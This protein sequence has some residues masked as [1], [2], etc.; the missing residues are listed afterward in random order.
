[1]IKQPVTLPPNRAWSQPNNGFIFGSVY[2]SRNVTFDVPGVVSLSPR[3]RILT[4]ES[5]SG[6]N[7]DTV[8]AFAYG[9][10]GATASG[11]SSTDQYI[12]VTSDALYLLAGALTNIGILTNASTPS[13]SAYSDGISWN[14]GFYCTQTSDLE[15]LVAGTWTG[16][17]MSLTSSVPHPL[18]RSASGNYLL[19]GNGNK[20]EKRTT[21]GVN[22]TAL[23]FP[24]NYQVVWIRSDYSRTLIGARALDGTNGAV[25]EWDE[26]APTWTNRF[27][28][29][30]SW[31][32]SGCFRNTD[33]FVVS[34][35]GRLMK[36]NG[37]G[38]STA[39]QWP[40]YKGLSGFWDGN[41]TG[42][43]ANP[44]YQRSMAVINGHLT[45]NVNSDI[46]YGQYDSVAYEN[47]PSGLWDF[48]E[49]TGLTH[50]YGLTCSNDDTDFA[51]MQNAVGT[52]ALFPVFI[53]SSAPD[54]SDGSFFL[55][56]A[57]MED[58]ATTY[59]TVVTCVDDGLNVGQLTTTR[60]ETSDIADDAKKLWVKYRGVFESTDLIRFKYKDQ[61]LEGL[62]F[63]TV[64]GGITWTSTTV[65]TSTN[66]NFANVVAGHEVTVF[67]GPGAGS[68]RHV[69]SISYANPTYTVT[70]DEA[71]TGVTAADVGGVIVD[72]FNLLE[73][74]ITNADTKGYKDIPLDQTD[75]RTWVQAKAELRGS[76]YVT[77]EEVQL[78]SA[79]DIIATA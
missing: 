47:F 29:D 2:S 18:E 25:F 78:V 76:S 72:N 58:G 38:F 12:V 60:I 51:Q 45:I 43:I 20:V 6:S 11:F 57:R 35:D 5:T 34:N 46:D 4:R 59:Y 16:S 13:M 33:F 37:G 61:W 73:I 3:T 63:S 40:I 49:S 7:L 77:I 52:G 41:S 1:M 67:I 21:G 24:S 39:A 27:D 64:Q 36:Y 23:T 14:D 42:I 66:T 15:K 30:F 62:P 56:G 50:R 48:E 22:T 65:F 55:T 31:P 69:A 8:L 32:Y 75:P 71:V 70:L 79:S 68:M 26:V 53:E 74:T 44:V 17:L 9:E 54:P 10:F 28:L 19:V